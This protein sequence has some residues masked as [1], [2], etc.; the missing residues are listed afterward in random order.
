M[1]NTKIWKERGNPKK[2]EEISRWKAHTNT[3]KL[4]WYISTITDVFFNQ[5]MW[6][7]RAIYLQCV[8]IQIEKDFCDSQNIS[9]KLLYAYLCLSSSDLFIFSVRL[10]TFFSYFCANKT[11]YYAR[12]HREYIEIYKHV[13]SITME[14]V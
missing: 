9:V 2:Y 6:T 14:K 4:N 7:Y 11:Q 5:I 13:N 10:F 1:D 8:H 3:W 12:L